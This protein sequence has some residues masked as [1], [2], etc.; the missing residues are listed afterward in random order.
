ML[1][2]TNLELVI[3]ITTI[4]N[5]FFE[6]VIMFVFDSDI[7]NFSKL[8]K[9]TAYIINLYYDIVNL[10]LVII[11]LYLLFVKKAKSV[12]AISLCIIILFKGFLHLI[13]SKRIYKYLHLSYETEQKLL[14]FHDHFALYASII[15][16]FLTTYLLRRIFFM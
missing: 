16:I 8:D 10:L 2:Y 15:N 7:Y 5:A 1:S 9:N 6:S 12:V 13:V 14:V 11:T 3:L 4:F